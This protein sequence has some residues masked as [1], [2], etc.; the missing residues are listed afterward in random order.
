MS[1]P[2]WS[3]HGHWARWTPALPGAPCP[4]KFRTAGALVRRTSPERHPA[5]LRP[6]PSTT[7]TLLRSRSGT[8]APRLGV[9]ESILLLVSP[10]GSISKRAS[11]RPTLPSLYW[12]ST[13]TSFDPFVLEERRTGALLTP[14]N[15]YFSG[16]FI[17][18]LVEDVRQ[19]SVHQGFTK[20]Q[21]TWPSGIGRGETTLSFLIL[22]WTKGLLSKKQNKT[23]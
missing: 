18:S 14:Y 4:A 23:K 7:P 6:Q 15:E 16:L 10:D 12:E 11:H 17:G 13:S 22:G 5:T 2:F 1:S 21:A 19:S 9:D 3:L 8:G 20:G